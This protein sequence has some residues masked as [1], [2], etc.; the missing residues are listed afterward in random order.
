[1]GTGVRR[2]G[3][4][5]LVGLGGFLLQIGTIALL[6]R[7]FEWAPAGATAVGVEIACL[8]NFLGH[9]RWTWRDYP[10]R[11]RREWLDRWSRYQLAKTASL[12]ANVA[13]TALLASAGGVPVELAN[14][15]A[16][17]ACAIPNFFIAERFVFRHRC[18]ARPGVTW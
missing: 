17:L 3:I 9:S 5:N 4:F 14:A 7:I 15:L 13:V 12:G 18:T 16:V 11:S 10:L 1:M 8:H 2:W 6:T